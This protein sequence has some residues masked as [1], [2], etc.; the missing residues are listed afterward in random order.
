MLTQTGC[1]PGTGP[2][3][4]RTPGAGRGMK[5]KGMGWGMGDAGWGGREAHRPG[6]EWAPRCQPR[7]GR[8]VL[9]GKPSSWGSDLLTAH[10]ARRPHP[11]TPGLASPRAL[12]ARVS[13]LALPSPGVQ[14]WGCH[15]G[16]MTW[17]REVVAVAEMPTDVEWEPEAL[18]P[19]A[20]RVLRCGR[21]PAPA[22]R[23]REA[24]RQK[25]PGPASHLLHPLSLG[26][27]VCKVGNGPPGTA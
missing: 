13:Q 3:P 8:G 14:P 25:R 2:T 27:P 26:L 9:H 19:P 18:G 24:G 10:S 12:P 21:A 4:P 5:P 15:T 22:P 6:G 16:S 17:P 23:P 7:G 11:C 20:S 1:P